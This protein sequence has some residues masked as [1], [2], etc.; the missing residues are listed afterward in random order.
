MT[1]REWECVPEAGRKPT[2]AE[3]Q[4]AEYAAEAGL[5]IETQVRI[6][7]SSSDWTCYGAIG[8]IEAAKLHASNCGLSSGSLVDVRDGNDPT[9]PMAQF[10]MIRREVYEVA[11]PR[12]GAE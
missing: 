2:K 3:Y 11:N 12:Q 5:K 9:R 6:V 8:W 7:G 1:V 4:A 10:E